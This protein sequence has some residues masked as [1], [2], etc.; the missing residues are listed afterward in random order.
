[1]LAQK[2]KFMEVKFAQLKDATIIVQ[3]YNESALRVSMFFKKVFLQIKTF[4]VVA[5]NSIP[6]FNDRFLSPFVT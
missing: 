3:R 2:S 6:N 1:M 5:S 4:L